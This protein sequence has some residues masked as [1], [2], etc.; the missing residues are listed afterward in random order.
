MKETLERLEFQVLK[1]KVY[2]INSSDNYT[3]NFILDIGATRYI[4]T[5]IESFISFK[6][7]NTTMN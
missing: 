4:V 6:S 2:L 1:E 3:A 5:L 7:C